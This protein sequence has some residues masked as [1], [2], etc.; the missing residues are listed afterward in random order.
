MATK[1]SATRKPASRATKAKPASRASKAAKKPIRRKVAAIPRGYHTAT[2]Y[3]VVKG[4]AEALAFYVKAFGAKQ[5]VCLGMPDGSVMH[6]EFQIG[7]SMIMLSE[8]NPG[9]GTKSPHTLGG[10]ATHVMLYVKDCD[11]FVARAVAAGATLSMPVSD[12]FWGDRY[13]K[14][15]DPFGHLWSIGTHIEDVSPKQMQK[16][17][18]AAIKQMPAA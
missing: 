17:A 11:A 18:D 7:D 14:V 12:Q 15:A 3:L 1:K 2:P 4:A 13:G 16:R 10:N 9:W 6:A 5:K 8:E